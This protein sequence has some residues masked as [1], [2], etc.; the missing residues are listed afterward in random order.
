MHKKDL[1]TPGEFLQYRRAD[2]VFIK[3][4][5]IGADGLAVHG[6]GFN[7][8]QVAQAHHAH[9]ERAR[10]GRGRQ[11]QDINLVAQAFDPFLMRYP[12]PM[13]FIDDDQA[14]L[15]EPDVAL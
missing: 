4:G 6:R 5:H 12:E 8:A 10:D 13:L 11:R 7:H 9:I 14:E 15:L 1:T 2:E 3:A